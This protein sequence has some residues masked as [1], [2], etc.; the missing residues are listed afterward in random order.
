MKKIGSVSAL[1]D[2]G[3]VRLSKSFYMRDFLYSEI[4]NFHGIP[5]LPESPD[6]AI[7]VGKVLCETLLEPLQDVFGR[8][9]IRSAYRSLAVNAHGNQHGV[10]CASNESNYARHIWDKLDVEG[11]KGAMA[12]VVI[13]W[14]TDQYE[15]GRSWTDLAYWIHN[16]LNYSEV[17]FF[18]K[19]CAFN[20]GWLE[21]PKR[22]IYSFVE[23][24]GYLIKGE[25]VNRDYEKFYADFPITRK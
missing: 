19:L 8:I 20:I 21:K 1:E 25:P 3:R 14:F 18:S 24:K 4:S 13:P 11:N 16:N 10:N 15:K 23:P 12:C 22:T 9:A 17:Q 2:L 5:N 6:M 7:E